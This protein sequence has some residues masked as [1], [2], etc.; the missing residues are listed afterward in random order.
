MAHH[1]SAEDRHRAILENLEKKSTVSVAELSAEL[2]VSEVTIRADLTQLEGAGKLRRVRGGAVSITRTVLMSYPEERITINQRAKKQVAR[3]ASS[4]V[5]D[6]DVIVVDIGT[7]SFYL[8]HELA[9]KKDLTIITGDLA[10]ANYASYNLPASDV[11]L[12]GGRVRKGHL[13]TAGTLT[14]ES[15]SKLYAD[16]AFI[17]CDGY[18]DGRGFSVEHDFSVTIKKAY[19]EHSRRA[20]MMLD[21][22]KLGRTS[23]YQMSTVE[24]FDDIVLDDDPNNIMRKAVVC[25]E[26]HPTLTLARTSWVDTSDIQ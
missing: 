15:M 5:D 1:L 19:I 3:V 12:L 8:V 16:K 26:R 24:D 13:Y 18:E 23:F 10:I 2:G 17:S 14:L 7:T 21:Q 11:I 9:Q 25:S 22:T 6:G 20:V 4:M